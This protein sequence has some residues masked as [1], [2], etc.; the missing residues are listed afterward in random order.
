MDAPISAEPVI[1]KARRPDS[2]AVKVKEKTRSL[3][4]LSSINSPASEMLTVISPSVGWTRV[5]GP[6]ISQAAINES[7]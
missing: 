3:L 6:D 2:M 4:K 5:P 7:R 1:A